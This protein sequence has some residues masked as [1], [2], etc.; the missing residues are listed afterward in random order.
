MNIQ[1]LRDLTNDQFFIQGSVIIKPR[2]FT[3]IKGH[4]SSVALTQYTLKGKKVLVPV[5]PQDLID[6]GFGQ[7]GSAENFYLYTFKAL[8]FQNGTNLTNG[9]III[10]KNKEY[11]IINQIDFATHGFYGYLITSL[12]ETLLND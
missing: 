5:K 8:T 12:L 2:D 6:T 1:M 9:D 7:F 3:Y 10:Y 11:Q 4:I